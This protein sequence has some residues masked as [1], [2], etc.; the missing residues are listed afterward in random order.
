MSTVRVERPHE[1]VALVVLDRPERKNALDNEAMFVTLPETFAQIADD[2]SIRVVVITGAGSAFCAGADLSA[3]M[4]AETEPGR[5]RANVLASHRTLVTMC[6]MP[7]S[8]IAAVNGDAVGAGLGL[9][10]ASDLRFISPTAR[11]GAPFTRF[12]LVP[13]FG[14]TR[15]LPPL[16][17]LDN[18]FDLLLTGRLV[19]AVEAVS[20]GFAPRISTNCRDDALSMAVQI[21]A[22]PPGAVSA[23]RG[24][25]YRELNANPVEALLELAPPAIVAALCAEEFTSTISSYRST[26]GSGRSRDESDGQS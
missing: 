12:G 10:A 8:V 5:I 21:A 14:L 2:R 24:L 13:D 6:T 16:I 4:F 11:L 7:Q 26:V 9:A 1:H 19:D 25:I 3:P 17:G 22:N 23:T 20:M 15:F 18:T